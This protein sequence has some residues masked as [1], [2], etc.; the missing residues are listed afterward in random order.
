MNSIARAGTD[1]S[2]TGAAIRTTAAFV[3]FFVSLIVVGLPLSR[4]QTPSILSILPDQIPTL[5]GFVAIVFVS[6]RVFDVSLA[7]Y[8]LNTDRRWMSDL[9]GGMLIG[10]LFQAVTTVAILT[11]GAGTIVEQWSMGV[12]DSVVAVVIVVGATVIAFLIVALGEDLLFRGVLIRES[13]TGFTDRNVSRPVATGLAVIVAAL[14]FGMVHLNAGA[15]GLSTEFAV[16]QA[17]V[18]GLYFGIAYVL[19]DSLALPV[20]IHLS[21]NLWTTVVFGQPDS[22]FPAA[23]RLTRQISL[24]TDVILL[25]FFPA[26]V[27][28]AAVFIWVKLT[29]GEHPD[30]SLGTTT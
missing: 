22:G 16:L 11:T 24:G 8:G 18:G 4:I 23:F 12:F 20:G 15:A 14:L 6:G 10:V 30:F 1:S 13:V 3:L 5:C 29:R 28:V 25:L 2:L 26:G 7:A 19:T 21:T 9:V 27:L 17:V